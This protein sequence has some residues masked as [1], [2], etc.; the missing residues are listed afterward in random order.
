MYVLKLGFLDGIPG[1]AVCSFCA[2]T[3]F[4]RYMKLFVRIRSGMPPPQAYDQGTT[5]ARAIDGVPDGAPAV[6]E[7]PKP[8]EA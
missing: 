1:L 8:S 5:T 2:F 7:R 4:V 6:P 3:R